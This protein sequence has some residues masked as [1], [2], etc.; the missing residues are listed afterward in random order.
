MHVL[1]L[2]DNFVP[3]GNAPAARLYEHAVRWVEAGHKVT[4][5]TCAPNF[6]EGRLFEGYKNRWHHVE[7]LEGIRIVRVKTYISANEGF[8]R[9]TLDYMS[10]MVSGFVAGLFQHKPDVVVGTSP[11]FFCAVGAW[12]LAAVRRKP[13]VFELRDLWPASVVAVG[14]MQDGHAI[15]LLEKLEL[16]L[17]RRAAAVVSVTQSF[18]DDLIQRGIKGEKI[19]VVRNGVDLRRYHPLIRDKELEQQF[20]LQDKFVVGYLGTHGMAHGLDKVLE[21]AALLRHRDDVVFLFAGGGAA[22]EAIKAAANEQELRN[23]RLLPRQP[24]HVMPRLWSLCDVTLIPLRDNPVFATV[25]PSKLF[26]AIGMSI[27]VIMSLP[28]GEATA[29]VRDAKV[30]LVVRPE[31]PEELAVTV[32]KMADAPELLREYRENALKNAPNYSRDQMANK[33]IEV[34]KSVSIQR[35]IAK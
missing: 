23:V 31:R 7:V 6:P 10:F 14:A 24:K 35:A 26:E 19:Y 8:L 32:E 20:D 17:Y 33:M 29:I 30:G 11:Q 12:A 18:R 4:V 3:E 28:D 13:F 34:L 22:R 15:Q 25:I 1:F 2:S 16:F 5:I 9:R 21:A 27:P